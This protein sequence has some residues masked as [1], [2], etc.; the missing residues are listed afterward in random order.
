MKPTR[1]MRQERLRFAGDAAGLA[2]VLAGFGFLGWG[3][4]PPAK[5]I[6]AHPIDIKQRL[7]AAQKSQRTAA[8][9]SV[10]AAPAALRP[11]MLIW[12]ASP[13]PATTGYEL[14]GSDYSS[15]AATNILRVGRTNQMADPLWL[16]LELRAIGDGAFSL[17]I[18]AQ[19]L[20]VAKVSGNIILTLVPRAGQANV[21]EA[22]DDFKT[23]VPFRSV[24]GS[25]RTT[26][27]IPT[28]AARRF[29]RL[30]PG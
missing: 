28:G 7:L 16:Y 24:S 21:I 6:V 10:P 26:L 22:S 13:D 14:R 3:L 2:L 25:V 20:L 5:P 15:L 27:V 18:I 12:D 11:A 1:E 8:A 4:V 23:W 17:P 30:R 19:R 29:Y 9:V